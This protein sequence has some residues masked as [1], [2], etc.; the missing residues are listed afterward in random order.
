Q[1]GL[2][3]PCTSTRTASTAQATRELLAGDLVV[4]RHAVPPEF[5]VGDVVA[6]AA[7][8]CLVPQRD[9]RQVLEQDLLG[10]V[11]D[12][13]TVLG[14][15]GSQ[16][17]RELLVEFLRGVVAVVRAGAGAV[18]GSEEVVQRRVVGLPAGAESRSEERRVGT[19][20]EY[21]GG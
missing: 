14:G 12:L 17:L 18:Q 3:S 1:E 7:L 6:P 19:G 20:G 16:A 15:L 2:P 4:E 11:E 5:D 10:F 8:D 13:R 21:C 9:G